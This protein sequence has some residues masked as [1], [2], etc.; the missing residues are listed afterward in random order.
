M[1][2]RM[3]DVIV[4]CNEEEGVVAGSWSK[5]KTALIGR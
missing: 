1:G 2:Q 3:R 4:L 5:T